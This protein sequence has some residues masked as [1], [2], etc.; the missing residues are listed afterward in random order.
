MVPSV[1][2]RGYWAIKL[3]LAYG[4]PGRRLL[5]RKPF[6]VV[7]CLLSHTHKSVPSEISEVYLEGKCLINS[8]CYALD[9]RR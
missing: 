1:L 6:A 4:K 2:Q 3:D 8:L 7:A 5:P 9:E